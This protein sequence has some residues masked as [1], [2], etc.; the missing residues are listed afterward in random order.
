M[1]W[2]TKKYIAKNYVKMDFLEYVFF[3]EAGIISRLRF[4]EKKEGL[5]IL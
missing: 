1:K 5:S 2:N 3:F 4:Y